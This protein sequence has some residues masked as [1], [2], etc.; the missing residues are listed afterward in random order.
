M[1]FTNRLTPPVKRK[2]VEDCSYWLLID[3]GG[4]E[5]IY[6]APE[7]NDNYVIKQLLS[8]DNFVDIEIAK[9]VKLNANDYWLGY[10]YYNDEEHFDIDTAAECAFNTREHLELYQYMND[11]GGHYVWGKVEHIVNGVVVETENEDTD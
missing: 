8:K 6:D 5:M 9:E 10:F 4:Y 2:I 1:T 11:A 3:V 7:P